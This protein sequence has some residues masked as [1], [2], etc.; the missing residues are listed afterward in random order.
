M[1]APDAN[2]KPWW[3]RAHE[4]AATKDELTPIREKIKHHLGRLDR[5][6]NDEWLMIEAIEMLIDLKIVKAFEDLA[7]ASEKWSAKS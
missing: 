6:W 7:D 4:Y 2:G 5:G 3:E 1:S